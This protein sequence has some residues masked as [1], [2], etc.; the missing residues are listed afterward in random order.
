MLMGSLAAFTLV[1]AMGLTM[2]RDAWR[3]IPLDPAIARLHAAA[4][5]V[6]SAFVI[7][8]AMNGDSR[9]FVNIGMAVVIIGLGLA[10]GF[11]ARKGMKVPRAL[12]ATHVGLAVVCYGLLAFLTLNPQATL[13]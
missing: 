4:A 6:G 5:L 9:L 10:M 7:V 3:G 2:L 11:A 1:A 8:V 13:I 12:L